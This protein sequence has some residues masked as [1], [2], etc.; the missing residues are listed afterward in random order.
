MKTIATT[1]LLVLLPLLGFSQLEKNFIDQPYIEVTG[2][3]DMEVTPDEIFLKIRINELDNKAKVTVEELEKMM[4]NTLLALNIDV[5]KN[6]TIVDFSSNFKSYLLKRTAIMTSKEYQLK[7][8][9]GKTTAA[10]FA[11][12]EKIGISNI[13]IEQVG[14]SKMEELQDQVKVLAIKAA[15]DK[16]KMLAEGIDQTIGGAL[17]V[18]ELGNGY[19][20]RVQRAGNIMLKTYAGAEAEAVLPDIEFEKIKLE[21]SILVKFELK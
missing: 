15:R 13:S 3:A 12:L 7:L 1:L 8:S 6:L 4:M 19:Y 5:E 9:D 2:K 20:P 11:E 14:H 17:F 10:V 18:Q 16:A 21:Y